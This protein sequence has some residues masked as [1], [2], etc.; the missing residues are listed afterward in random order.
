MKIFLSA[1]FLFC[2]SIL[3]Y[4]QNTFQKIYENPQLAQGGT[5][6]SSVHVAN[7]TIYVIG[8]E[9]NEE[10]I[11]PDGFVFKF[12]FQ[13]DLLETIFFSASLPELGVNFGK[14]GG[15]ILEIDNFIIPMKEFNN[16][17]PVNESESLLK[18]NLNGDVIWNKSI[19]VDSI[20][21]HI[22]RKVIPF[23]DGYAAIG[24][25]NDSLFNGTFDGVN[26][27]VTT[28]D[29]EGNI[30]WSKDYE[31]MYHLSYGQATFDGGLILCSS[32][33]LG[34]GPNHTDIK[35]VK[36]DSIGNVQ[37]EHIFGGDDSESR[38]PIIQAKDSSYV[39]FGIDLGLPGFGFT[40][41]PFWLKRLIDANNTDGYTVVDD[42]KYDW[43]DI[44]KSTTNALELP[45]SS[46]IV[47]GRHGFNE[48]NVS[49]AYNQAFIGKLTSNL[50]SVWSH[51]YQFVPL[52]DNLWPK[53]ILHDIKL[54]PDNGFVAT[55]IMYRV[56]SDPDYPGVQQMIL[57]RLD[58]DGCLEPGCLFTGI[59]EI[60]IGLE[61]TMVLYPNPVRSGEP[62]NLQF[63]EQV[64]YAMPYAKEHTQIIIYDM[65]GR[66]VYRQSLSP[67]G[68]N[69]SF[70]VSV[71]IPPLSKG[72]YTLQWVGEAWYDAVQ[73]VVE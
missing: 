68:S 55:G 3:S 18:I 43:S 70:E 67:T 20:R 44:T 1:L 29:H 72:Q 32:I 35:I 63:S 25:I 22:Y 11:K 15:N 28:T 56:P 46:I 50:D 9:T 37:W 27:L 10:G 49:Y 38:Q 36:L 47:V 59:P 41:G 52:V 21:R 17:N 51:Y 14:Y 58:E 48:D 66:E 65:M 5:E 24:D 42:I 39:V 54:M 71:D 40:R 33:D 19:K 34:P 8:Y 6:A 61:N 53:H 30:L 45:D 26:G 60:I 13:G 4:S 23:H 16:T 73:F 2:I 62:L 12:N 57:I 69:D 31:D 7:D 64:G